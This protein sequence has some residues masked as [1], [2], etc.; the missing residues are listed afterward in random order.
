MFFIA[1]IFSTAFSIEALGTLV[2]V[3]GLSTLFGANPIIIALAIALDA[4]KIVVVTLLYSYWRQMNMMMKTYALIASAVTMIITSAG[5]AGYLSGEFQ[6]AIMNTQEG[7]TQ[8]T[9]LKEQVAKYETRKKQIDD[10]IDR[11][12]DQTNAK[13][14]ARIIANFK[15]EQV[16]LQKK[17]A[18]I[19]KELP[20]LQVKQ[21]GVEAKAGPILY[22]S[23]AFNIP[24]EQAVKYVIL[25][26]IF[27]FDPLAVYLIIAGNFLLSKRREAAKAYKEP[28]MPVPVP[29]IPVPPEQPPIQNV[30][31][32]LVPEE[33]AVLAV[34]P[35]VKPDVKI[36]MPFKELE[37]ELV[38]IEPVLHENVVT[39]PGMIPERLIPIE[40]RN[41]EVPAPVILEA[42]KPVSDISVEPVNGL[43]IKTEPEPP[44]KKVTKNPKA[45]EVI[46]KTQ[47]LGGGHFPSNSSLDSVVGG[48][49]EFD[50]SESAKIADTY[51]QFAAPRR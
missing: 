13:D 10:L 1:L 41:T 38:P 47:L 16:D 20:K 23:K 31:L 48:D 29:D 4:G 14:R 19:D 17:I 49:I 50:L 11:I 34:K 21:I 3:I 39:A 40:S 43:S 9:I 46:T 42:L 30:E 7:A 22:V 26:I 45:R 8:V 15:A 33:P 5:A 2:S 6:K 27:V 37:L 28:E 44:A 35:D 12:P 32:S 51:R 36:K 18:Q 24:V 25:T